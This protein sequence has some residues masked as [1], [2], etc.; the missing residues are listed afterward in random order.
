MFQELAH[1]KTG[2]KELRQMKIS[3]AAAV[4]GDDG[5]AAR[6]LRGGL[7]F[8]AIIHAVDRKR[9]RAWQT[10]SQAEIGRAEEQA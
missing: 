2:E 7:V 1:V 9:T 6:P 3:H 4:L 5:A 8:A 10:S